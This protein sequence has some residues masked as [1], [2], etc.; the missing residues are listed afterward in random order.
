MDDSHGSPLVRFLSL[1]TGQRLGPGRPRDLFVAPGCTDR[2]DDSYDLVFAPAARQ[3]PLAVPYDGDPSRD[4]DAQVVVD[5]G[6]PIT[7][8]PPRTAEMTPTAGAA[9]LTCDAPQDVEYLEDLARYAAGSGMLPDFLTHPRTLVA[10][11]HVIF[12]LRG[13]FFQPATLGGPSVSGL[14]VQSPGLRA[15]RASGTARWVLAAGLIARRYRLRGETPAVSGVGG[16][17]FPGTGEDRALANPECVLVRSGSELR[18]E[19]VDGRPAQRLSE[20]AARLVES[21]QATGDLE[22][23]CERMRC[24]REPAEDLLARVLRVGGDAR[25]GAAA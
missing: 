23:V 19:F 16:C 21:Y 15:L 9:V 6:L 5:G 7:F 11:L 13:T 1:V 24:R 2:T 18:A 8:T 20:A 22:A 17:L 12:P 14:G 10:D 3:L 25:A 4:G